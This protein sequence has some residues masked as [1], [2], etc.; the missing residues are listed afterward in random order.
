MD[1]HRAPSDA[2]QRSYARS[3][4][5]RRWQSQHRTRHSFASGR[6]FASQ[7]FDF[8]DEVFIATSVLFVLGFYTVKLAS[9][10]SEAA[11]T[12]ADELKTGF[13]FTTN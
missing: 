4:D 10:V 7:L 11:F 5:A 12:V 8:Y 1:R 13:K 6:Q 2:S 9:D 3:H